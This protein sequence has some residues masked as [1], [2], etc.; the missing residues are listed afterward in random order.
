MNDT[1]ND[2][3]T[4]SISVSLF[5]RKI[6]SVCYPL[7]DTVA[8]FHDTLY[9]VRRRFLEKKRTVKVR[10]AG[11]YSGLSGELQG[12]LS[13]R[14]LK[15]KK[16]AGGHVLETDFVQYKQHGIAF[17]DPGDIL[18]CRIYFDRELQWVRSEYYLPEDPLRAKVSFKPDPT[19][20]VVL[21]FNYNGTTGTTKETTLFPVPYTYQTAEQSLQNAQFGEDIFLVSTDSG[22]FAYCPQPEQQKRLE[23]LEEN[24]DASVMLSIGWE[25]RDGDIA[26]STDTDTSG[27]SLPVLEETAHEDDGLSEIL[28][29]MEEDSFD[30]NIPAEEILPAVEASHDEEPIP[31]AEEIPAAEIAPEPVEVSVETDTPAP[32]E[33]CAADTTTVIEEIPA[34]I[35]VP[36]TV[37]EAIP[38]PAFAEEVTEKTVP[39][40]D[41]GLS[42]TDEELMYV[43][44]V[45]DRLLEN[46]VITH[47]AEKVEEN[48]APA[49]LIRDGDT[50]NYTGEMKNGIREGFGRTTDTDG[51]TLYEGEYKNDKRDGFGAHHY[52]S[53]AVSYIGDFKNDE[54]HGFGVSFRE[55]DHALHVSRWIDGKPEGYAA[56]FDPNGTMR[57]AG[58]ILNGQKQGAG[59]SIDTEND[60]VFIAKYENNEPTGQGALFAGDGTLLYAGGWLDGKRHGHGTEFDRNGDVIFSGEWKKDRYENGILY[61]KV[62]GNHENGSN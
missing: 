59:I 44:S 28:F 38:A 7:F 50:F 31:V 18:R 40:A 14:K 12:K 17:Y 26:S 23:F 57:Y 54:R 25:V 56:L 62:T 5:N 30:E 48:L 4:N 42:F 52:R 2:T 19:R 36:E 53:G 9:D 27:E 20:D 3:K 43:H 33:A 39:A 46:P 15:W 16:Q 13:S 37:T 58:K 29:T 35:N 61:K 6:Y 22:E 24:R 32:E 8:G 51:I 60:T 34:E 10:E 49:A 1:M 41:I 21:R 47:T 55:N 45:L 11:I